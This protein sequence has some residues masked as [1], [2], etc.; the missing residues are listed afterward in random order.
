MY[1]RNLITSDEMEV[2]LDTHAGKTRRAKIE[3]LLQM[4]DT[5]G[6]SAYAILEACLGEESSHPTHHELH[7]MISI[8]RKRKRYHDEACSIP[9][10]I[11]QR[12]RME[13]PFCGEVYLEFIANIQKC[14][15]RSSWVELESLA[16][17]FIQ[18][19]EDPQ[20]RAMAMIEKGYSFSCRRGMRKVA[21]DCLDE[22]QITARQVNVSNHY[23][24]LARC[25]HIQATMLRY[26][27]KDDESL[28]KN[29]AAYHLLSNCAPG[30]DASR[31][32][33]GIA[34]ARLEKL[35]KTH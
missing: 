21:F 30:D 7:E 34:C 5:K 20:L 11:P 9:K 33:Y 3:Q 8:S 19:N 32:M 29:Q 2:L 31:V 35:G 6:P 14:Y 15:Q 25:K 22:A 28:T 13:K 12:L 26:E 17:G 23:F 4:L 10:R 27:G 18:R 24:L 1:A 16:Q